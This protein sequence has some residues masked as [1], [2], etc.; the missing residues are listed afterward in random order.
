M[1]I[2]AHQHFW[3]YNPSDYVWIDSRMESLKKD[4]LPEDLSPHLSQLG[5]Q[6]TIAVQARQMEVETNFL[7]QLAEQN[8]WILG[9]V[10]WVDFE[11]PDLEQ[12]IER[13]AQHPRLKGFRE[14]IHD[15]PDPNYAISEVHLGAIKLLE[16]Y[17]LAYDL[18]LRPG[19]IPAAIDLVDKFPN[20][21]FILDHIAK[22]EIRSGSKEPWQSRVKELAKRPNVYC[23]LSGLVTEADWTNWTREIVY[24]YLDICLGAFGPQ[25]LM[26]GSDWPVCTLAGTYKEVMSLTLGYLESLS[27][28]EQQRVFSETCLEAYKI[29]YPPTNL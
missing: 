10:G 17:N 22:P 23:K 14:L 19:H 18:L 7:L 2:D 24:P 8:Q 11:G 26:V 15:M 28:S 29:T 27:A 1:K 21:R 13:F 6:G 25:R 9:V 3:K 4:Y 16:K 12:R 5:I 20:Q